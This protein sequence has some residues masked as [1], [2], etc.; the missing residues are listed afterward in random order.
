MPKKR[1]SRGYRFLQNFST[2]AGQAGQDQWVWGEVFNEKEGGFFLDIGAHDGR[3]LSNSYLLERQYKWS[4]ICI[5]ANPET[6]V[7]L[8]KNRSCTCINACVDQVEGEVDFVVAG[9][10]GG[11]V[12]NDLDN[13]EADSATRK[14]VRL[15]TFTLEKLLA[16]NGAPKEIDYL[17]IDVEGAEERV[18]G[19]FNFNSYIFRAV[20]IERPS[21]RLREQFKA[22]GYRLIKE[23]PDLDCFYIHE[24]YVQKYLE[25]LYAFNKKKFL[26]VRW[27]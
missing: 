21:A 1:K 4:G 18:L 16:A 26:K 12:S 10:L 15:K 8:R 14:T 7:E 6:F 5:E 13:K 25:C 27:R 9:V 20:T 22:A 23:I 11:I 19:A 2:G 3:H 17:S 24:S